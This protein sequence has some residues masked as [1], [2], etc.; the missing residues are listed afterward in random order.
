MFVN[1]PLRVKCDAV[2]IVSSVLSYLNLANKS[3]YYCIENSNGWKIQNSIADCSYDAK[4]ILNLI[5][6]ASKILKPL[7]K[8]SA[9]IG[10]RLQIAK[11]G[12]WPQEWCKDQSLGF[13]NT[14][15][16]ITGKSWYF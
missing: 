9:S 11:D 4:I 12:C 16:E 7:S 2:Y 13:A 6:L 3:Y 1:N 15:F 8:G 5:F 10:L 14:H